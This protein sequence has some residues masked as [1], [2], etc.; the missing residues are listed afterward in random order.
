MPREPRAG[1]AT[2]WI[3]VGDGPRP[4]LFLHC[5]LASARSLV[6]LMERVGDQLHGDAPD[7]P[8]HGRSA[9]WDGSGDYVT[10]ATDIAETFCD[11]PRDII[12]H[13]LGA[14][15]AL[16]LMARRPD[17]VRRAV[18]IEPVLFAAARGTPAHDTYRRDHAEMADAVAAGD[19][20]AA[21]RAFVQI[22]GTAQPW[23][24]L[25]APVRQA[26]T[27]RIHLVSATGP[28]LEDDATGLLDGD[29]LGRV[30]APILLIRGELSHPIIP[31]IFDE[32]ARQ[33]PDPRIETI[34]GAGHMA[35]ITHP[36]EVA[37]LVRQHLVAP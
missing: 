36:D 8:G 15:V 26:M 17:L 34:A 33:L 31:A 14:V 25:P 35:P 22:W 12:G 30:D 19:P 29:R 24:A 10:R 9:D 11:G 23:D 3:T 2:N 18:L 32:L 1:V 4:G 37:L 13:S 16:S 20:M 5:S 7:L 27:D 28:A 21:T 6:P